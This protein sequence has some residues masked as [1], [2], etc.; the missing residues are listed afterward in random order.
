MQVL[1]SVRL[2]VPPSPSA[3]VK[4]EAFPRRRPLLFLVLLGLAGCATEGGQQTAAP[5][6]T[7]KAAAAAPAADDA[8]KSAEPM[9]VASMTANAA[10]PDNPSFCGIGAAVEW[11]PPAA[12]VPPGMARFYGLWGEGMWDGVLCQAIAVSDIKPDGTAKVTSFTGTFHPW[13]F[14]RPRTHT[15]AAAIAGDTLRYESYWT[16]GVWGEFTV[17]GNTIRGVWDGKYRVDLPR[18]ASRAAGEG[19]K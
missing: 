9:K 12:D 7:Q 10:L 8:Q 2:A 17:N 18:V 3:S 4:R 6:E 16:K 11:V 14:D 19:R 13:R 5:A 1:G 15:Y